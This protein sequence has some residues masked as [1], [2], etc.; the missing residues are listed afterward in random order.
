M[1]CVVLF[2]ALLVVGCTE[3]DAGWDM[4]TGTSFGQRAIGEAPPDADSL[5]VSNYEES[6]ETQSKYVEGATVRRYEFHCPSCGRVPPGKRFEHGAVNQCE[7]GLY[8]QAMGNHLS[9][10]R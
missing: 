3:R 7:C 6:V 9:V 4:G 10:W 5:L 8:M 2:L 1:K